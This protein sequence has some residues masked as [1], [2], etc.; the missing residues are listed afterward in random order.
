MSK[1][2]V[3]LAK[4]YKDFDARHK[5]ASA[6]LKL[7]N[8][9]WGECEV[10]LL[11]AMVEDGV[12][13]VKLEGVGNFSMATKAFLSV[14]AANKPSFFIYLKKTGNGGLLKEDVNSATLSSF[15]KDH[16]EQLVRDKVNSGKDE[17]DARK[18]VLEYLNKQGASYHTERQ[19]RMLKA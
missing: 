11:E 17:V 9:E 19:I 5:A 12:N 7:L 3:E 16:L 8:E 2:I 4:K 1:Q 13:S 18:E 6:A 14:T 10:E 15:L